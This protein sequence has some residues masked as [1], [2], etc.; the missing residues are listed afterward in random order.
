MTLR[1]VLC[2]SCFLLVA[3]A[4]TR[5]KLDA[6]TIGYRQTNLASNLPGVANN[7]AP[8]LANPWG[9][10]FL[11]D[12]PF[13]IADNKVGR[14]TVRDATGLGVAPG[15]FT[16]PNAAGT[17]FDH[18]NGI[19]ADQNSSFGAHRSS[20]PSFWSP[21]LTVSTS[22]SVSRHGFSFRSWLVDVLFCSPLP[23]SAW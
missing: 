19:V 8:G 2:I 5:A 10:A 20:N 7:L 9:I 14:I 23:C 1:I 17:G 18:P 6:Q 22:T 16:V 3:V 15:G 21:T 13:F 4:L 11:S 12:Q